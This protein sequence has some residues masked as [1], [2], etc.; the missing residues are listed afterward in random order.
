[1]PRTYQATE[2]IPC[3]VIRS[4]P[5]NLFYSYAHEDEVFRRRLDS[6][7][8]LLQRQ[9]LIHAWHDRKIGAGTEWKKQIDAQLRSADVVLLLVSADFLGSGYCFD[10]ELKWALDRHATGELTVVPVIVRPV[11]WAGAPFTSL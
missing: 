6:H 1:M 4:V 2:D 11:D 7:L 8:S 3:S 9:G 10:V 5:L